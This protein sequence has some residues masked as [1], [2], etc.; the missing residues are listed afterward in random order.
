[1][2]IENA[3]LWSTHTPCIVIDQVLLDLH[4]LGRV[5]E[6]QELSPQASCLPYT[7]HSILASDMMLCDSF[8]FLEARYL[9][10]LKREAVGGAP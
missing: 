2:G 3:C 8:L 4:V 5:C 6:Q 9:T 7:V 1:M 10:L